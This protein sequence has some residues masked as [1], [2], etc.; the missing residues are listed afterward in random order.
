[1][2]TEE[3]PVVLL[4]TPEDHELMGRAVKALTS[5]MLEETPAIMVAVVVVCPTRKEDG[6][7]G[8]IQLAML[9]SPK[10]MPESV[11][12][13]LLEPVEQATHRL[14]ERAHGATGLEYTGML[15]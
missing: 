10:E 7:I 3:K 8:T 5:T 2:A 6:D 11:R 15:Q 4:E 14:F 12:R 13:A 9:T 1:M